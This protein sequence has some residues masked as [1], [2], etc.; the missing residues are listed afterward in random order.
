[1]IIIAAI[2]LNTKLVQVIDGSGEIWVYTTRSRPASILKQCGIDLSPGDE[3]RFSGFKDNFARINLLE[4]FPVSITADQKTREV[5]LAKGTVA[6]AL[7]KAGV[8]LS[9]DDQ[10][11][12]PFSKA[13]VAGMKIK[14]TR[15]S[16]QTVT[17]K[18]V[19]PFGVSTS[20]SP[21]LKK[22]SSLLKVRGHNGQETVVKKIKYIDGKAVGATLLRRVVDLSP[23]NSQ[24]LVGSSAS[25]PV[26]VLSPPSWLT[27][28]NRGTPD[29]YVNVISAVATAYTAGKG[30]GTASGRRA[31]AG[32][33]A[34]DP[35]VIPY[36]TRLYIMSSDGDFVYGYAIAADTG[37]FVYN[38]SG[39]DVDLYFNT[40]AECRKFGK[41]TVSI[42]VLG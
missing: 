37:E 7:D 14:I 2:V 5:L 38:G 25:T 39:V 23:T 16:Y 21:L 34:V 42:Y 6:D 32:H 27:L 1:M 41:R 18:R 20:T 17:E 22:G 13:V 40:M 4:A 19:L 31:M 10:I 29:R 8:T 28:S 9:P 26:S 15:V 33:V 30:A 35:R 12:Q 36:G 11:N 3:Y 24:V